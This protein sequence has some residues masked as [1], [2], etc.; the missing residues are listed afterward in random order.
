M[1]DEKA[2]RTEQQA[3]TL[4]PSTDVAAINDEAFSLMKEHSLQTVG[5]DDTKIGYM[6]MGGTEEF[7]SLYGTGTAFKDQTSTILS[8]NG[9]TE[10]GAGISQVYK[11]ASEDN[12]GAY[13]AFGGDVNSMT[14][15]SLAI[16]DVSANS[17][18]F[19]NL[20]KE[21]SKT[22]IAES[23]REIKKNDTLEGIARKVLGKDASPKE[24]ADLAELMKQINGIENERKIQPGDKVQIP[25]RNT[26]G[27]YYFQNPDN[28][29]EKITVWRGG[30]RVENKD[31][32]G[33]ER[34]QEKDG[35]I[36]GK[37]WGPKPEDNYTYER[38]KDGTEVV[39][40]QKGNKTTTNPDGSTRV[41][42]VDGTG[43]TRDAKGNENH[44]G[45]KPEDNYTRDKDAKRY[46][47]KDGNRVSEFND[48][49][50]GVTDK[51][52]V[53]T[54][55]FQNGEQCI[56]EPSGR[57][58]WKNKDGSV[59]VKNP[60]GGPVERT[61]KDGTKLTRWPNGVEKRENPDGTGDV[62]TPDGHGGYTK[63][64][65]GPKPEN[66]YNETYSPT[67]GVTKRVDGAGTTTTTWADRTT[68]VENKDGTGYVRKPDGSEHHWGPEAKDNFDKPAN[69]TKQLDA[70]RQ[71]L[72]EAADKSGMT[73]EQRDKFNKDMEAFE[74][75]AKEQGLS[76]DEVAKTYAQTTR[77]LEATDGKVPKDQREVLAQNIMHHAANPENVDQ[78]QHNTCNTTTLA[79]NLF[80]KNPSK[81][82]EMIASTAITGEW[83]APDGKVIKID[84]G[85]LV[86]GAEEIRNPPANGMRSHATQIL[87][88]V[89]TNDAT[90]RRNPPVFYRQET[91]TGPGDSGERLY[92]QNGKMITEKV[93]DPND[94]SK[95]VDKPVSSPTLSYSEIN[96]IGRRL[97]GEDK[98]MRFG[99]G[100]DGGIT[101]NSE[102]EMR[103]KIKQAKDQ[104][105][106]PLV[107]G[108]DANKPP[109]GNS[110]EFGAHV[111]T[112][113]GYDEKTGRVRVSNQW[114]SQSDQWVDI[115]DLYKNTSSGK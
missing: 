40:D 18:K 109:F 13:N 39:T 58:T 56:T 46:T 112:I 53:T 102:Q 35:T 33:Y 52:G 93:K 61:E 84:P 79:E 108:V 3:Q 34:Q 73:P 65:W 95:Y 72:K 94:P 24:V 85:S 75:R 63:Q 20:L 97:T 8:T 5:G 1:V 27:S 87:N 98:V 86:P 100:S 50:R 83:K 30:V 103:D 77:L 19:G 26:D 41:D 47:D 4:G 110:P 31:G 115:K 105:K 10:L 92:D 59:T 48:G 25:G 67:D 49:T 82:A 111:V 12:L 45:P 101:Y 66:N 90:Q 107:L 74:K 37:G 113:T 91:P 64:G 14:S 70:E 55:T 54:W 2:E 114:G 69:D 96:Q 51:N 29:D 80:T 21:N 42:N 71:R 81:A 44:W 78:G 17:L 88:V 68:K 104:G 22:A 16:S 99:N 28:S 6:L 89:M 23:E 57:E 32:T 11:L 15:S 38:S 76:P 43:Y 62:T 106:L 36:K 9:G 60:N 7:K